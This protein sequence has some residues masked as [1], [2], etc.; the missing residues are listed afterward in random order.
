MSVSLQSHPSEV[1]RCPDATS[2]HLCASLASCPR[3]PDAPYP[4]I[5][6]KKARNRV[7]PG[8]Q[9]PVGCSAHGTAVLLAGR[10][11]NLTTPGRAITAD[12]SVSG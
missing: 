9:R 8:N 2:N 11:L 10:R 6:A 5:R 7:A 1:I 3:L 4:A 12:L